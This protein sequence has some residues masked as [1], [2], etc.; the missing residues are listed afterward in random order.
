MA[1]S[2]N[3]LLGFGEI[4]VS[5]VGDEPADS[6]SYLNNAH[7][8]LL[9]DNHVFKLPKAIG[10]LP[11][12]NAVS[13]PGTVTPLA[14]GRE[15]SK[16]LLKSIKPNDSI[17]GLVTQHNPETDRPTFLATVPMAITGSVMWSTS[18]AITCMTS[19]V[20][21]RNATTSQA[22]L[23]TRNPYLSTNGTLRRG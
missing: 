4:L 14:V 9:D 21:A 23:I 15:R 10:I 13:Y 11:I 12:R 19:M 8:D 17:I 2:I 16:R 18:S 20:P 22:F 7:P 6:G 5:V 3:T 1:S